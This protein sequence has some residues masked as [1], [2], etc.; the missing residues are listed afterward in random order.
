MCWGSSSLVVHG[1]CPNDV[2]A[3]L[4]YFHIGVILLERT[5]VPGQADGSQR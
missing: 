3:R 4:H 1:A 2:A 5:I